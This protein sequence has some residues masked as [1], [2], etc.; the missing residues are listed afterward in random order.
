MISDLKLLLIYISLLASAFSLVTVG[1]L[2]E[3]TTHGYKRIASCKTLAIS[4]D[5]KDILDIISTSMEDEVISVYEG[6]DILSLCEQLDRDQKKL[7]DQIFLDSI[8][9]KLI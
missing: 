1:G 4:L 7:K 8:K 2:S 9:D 6:T 3:L 5:R